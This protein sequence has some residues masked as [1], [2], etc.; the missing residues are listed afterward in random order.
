MAWGLRGRYSEKLVDGVERIISS[1]GGVGKV[2]VSMDTRP[3]SPTLHHTVIKS[4]LQNGNTVYDVGI[5]PTP[6]LSYLTKVHGC[7]GIMI[8]ASHNPEYDNGIK[9][10]YRGMEVDREGIIQTISHRP[11]SCGRIHTVDLCES[12][13]RHLCM[14]FDARPIMKRRPKVIVECGNGTAGMFTPYMLARAGVRVVTVNSEHSNPFSRDSEPTQQSLQYLAGLVQEFNA[15]FAIAHDVDADRC[16]II[17][18]DGIM[19][20]DVQL[21]NMALYVCRP[22]SLFV[23]TV[24]A[25]GLVVETVSKKGVGVEITPV[26]SSFVG[27]KVS[28]LR[29]AFGGEPCGE[30]IFPGHIYSADGI[31][32]ALKFTELFCVSG[33]SAFPEYPIIRGTVKVRE[34]MKDQV[35]ARI[36]NELALQGISSI[37]MVDGLL[38]NHN[39][40]KVLIRKSNTQEVIRITVEHRDVHMLNEVYNNMVNLVKRSVGE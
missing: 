28:E 10:F 7:L 26:G 32:T 5:G 4:L 3:S 17:T 6:Y 35:M 12:Y 15:D 34:G 11:Q 8:T 2:F 1:M 24:E 19:S 21:L 9:V 25:S 20:Q 36:E 22:G 31:V 40:A 27:R 30:Y 33:F 14:L 39:G 23:T 29:A 16:R 38:F 37:S 18:K 13:L